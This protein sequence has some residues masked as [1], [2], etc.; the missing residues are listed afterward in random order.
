MEYGRERKQELLRPNL[1]DV[2]DRECLRFQYHG[3]LPVAL[4]GIYVWH[5]LALIEIFEDDFVLQ[6]GGGT[7]GHPSGNVPC[8]MANRIA[9]ETYVKD[10]NEGHDLASKGNVIIREASK[11]SPE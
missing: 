3:V 11:W 9:L 6:F 7:L 1:F 10:H 8:V 4:G 5:M 2:V